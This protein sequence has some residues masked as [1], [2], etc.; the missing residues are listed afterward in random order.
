MHTLP[1]NVN[2]IEKIAQVTSAF[3]LLSDPTRCRILCLLQRSEGGMC[4]YELAD[5]ADISHS[6]ASHQL[7]KLEARSVVQSFREGQNICYRIRNNAFTK[8][9]LRVLEIFA[10]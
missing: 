3:R 10:R 2:D 1:L 4:V 5:A 7:A 6:A 8:N 9:L